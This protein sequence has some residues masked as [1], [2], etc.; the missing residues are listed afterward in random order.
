MDREQIKEL[1]GQPV[2]YCGVLCGLKG[3]PT[4]YAYGKGWKCK[5]CWRAV[6][7]SETRYGVVEWD[8]EKTER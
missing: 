8:D 4:A 2:C 7:L 3:Q 1:L 6:L 5:D